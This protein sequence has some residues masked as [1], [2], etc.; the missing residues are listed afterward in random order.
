MKCLFALLVPALAAA[1][2]WPETVAEWKRLSA[3]PAAVADRRLWNEYG[4]QEAE[5]VVYQNGDR[6]LSATAWRLQDST[7]A[8]AVFDMLRPADAKPSL[9]A[10][11]AAEAGDALIAAH[12]NYV[13]SFQGKLSRDEAN[14]FLAA[15][16]RAE[17]AALPTLPDFFPIENLV[18]N[19]ERYVIGPAGL[20]RFSPGIPP[21]VA[22]FHLGAEAQ[23]GV[24]RAPGGDL[25]L[26]LFSYPTPQMAMQQSE[27]FKKLAGAVV[28]RSGPLVAVVLSPAN[29]DA[30]ERLLSL[31]R[32]Q[33]QV[34][35]TEYVPTRRDN[36]GDLILTIFEL[37]GVL[38]VFAVVSGLAFGGLRTA[39]RRG[40]EPEPMITLHLGDRYHKNPSA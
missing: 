12:G 7:G 13:A 19:S 9:V 21:S 27:S 34:T 6:K 15:L 14:A 4:F 1:A 29:A 37:I 25:K 30:A 2:V 17:L 8:M 36:I 16:P 32:Y 23:V 28:K 18:P 35:D 24:F 33:A 39:L 11:L 5:S 38:L 40:R 20:E 10:K 26:A 3:T 22:A 31:V